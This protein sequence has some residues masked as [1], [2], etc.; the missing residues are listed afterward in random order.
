MVQQPQIVFVLDAPADVIY[1]RK[2]E[3]ALDEIQ[4]QLDEF[5]NLRKLGDSFYR[6]DAN[7]TPGEMVQDA[8]RIILEKFCVK[9]DK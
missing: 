2:K 7:Q 8:K 1:S 3:L 5:A 9:I 6:V 4:R